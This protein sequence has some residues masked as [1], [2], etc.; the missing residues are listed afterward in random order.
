MAAFIPLI[1]AGYPIVKPLIISLVAH[2]EHLFGA[3]TGATKLQAVLDAITPIATA[4]GTAG[5]IPGQLN[6]ETLTA[7]I[8]TVV[9]DLNKQG[10]LNAAS[11]AKLSTT[12]AGTVVKSGGTSTLTGSISFQ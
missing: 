5:K 9:A 12:P 7:Y 2:V 4:L 3:K 10:V 6:A 1:A 8:N 11:A